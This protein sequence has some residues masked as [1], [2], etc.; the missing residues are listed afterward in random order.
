MNRNLS[1]N[2]ENPQT[3]ASD[4]RY[5][6]AFLLILVISFCVIGWLNVSVRLCDFCSSVQ[7]CEKKNARSSLEILSLTDFYRWTEAFL[8][9]GRTHKRR[10]ATTDITEPFC[11]F[12]LY[13]S[14]LSVDLMSLCAFV[15]SVLLCSSV[16]EKGEYERERPLPQPL[17]RREGA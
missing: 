12:W 15:K 7:F 2:R 5:H 17:P 1:A 11:Q 14:V 10:Q 9:T 8:L 6:R 4:D 13:R 16:R 3:P